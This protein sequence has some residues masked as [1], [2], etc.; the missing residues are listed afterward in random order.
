MG[1]LIRKTK[2]VGCQTVLNFAGENHSGNGGRGVFEVGLE[3][4]LKYTG[5]KPS[6]T[7]AIEQRPKG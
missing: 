5:Q 2:Y 6:Y 1:R 4:L 7:L 3:L